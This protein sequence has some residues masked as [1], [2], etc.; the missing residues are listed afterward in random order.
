MSS[1]SKSKKTK[2]SNIKIPSELLGCFVDVVVVVVVAGYLLL[3]LLLSF[4]VVHH[5]LHLFST[6]FHLSRRTICIKLTTEVCGDSELSY[7]PGDHVGV[8][9]GN[10]PAIVEEVL[11]RLTED[12][13]DPDQVTKMEI[14]K[15]KHTP[16]G[17]EPLEIVMLRPDYYWDALSKK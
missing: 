2:I 5:D 1:C 4:I 17:S 11:S 8:F 16:L 13:S 7:L 15:E 6:F 10:D 3:L 9:A 12:A 14:L